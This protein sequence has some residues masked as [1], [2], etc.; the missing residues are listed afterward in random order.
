VTWQAWYPVFEAR[1]D[2]GNNPSISRPNNTIG[3]PAVIKPGL[4]FRGSMHVPLRFR[5]GKFTLFIRPSLTVG[6][7]NNYL[8]SQE[9][10]SYDYGQTM[11]AGRFYFS[12]SHLMAARDIYPRLAQVVDL[13]YASYPFDS[14]NYGSSFTLRTMFHFP[15]FFRNNIIRIRYE[16]EFQSV[17]KFLNFNLVK[18]P[19]G[20]KNIISEDLSFFSADYF[21]PLFYPDLNIGSL[22]YL[23]RI[24]AGIFYDYGKGT[25]NYYLSIGENGLE[26]SPVNN[27]SEIFTSYGAE[28]ISDFHVLRLPYMVSAGV[29]AAWR[30]G[31]YKP[32]L[33]AILSI[34]I[35]GMSIGQ[36]PKL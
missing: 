13:Y 14:E 26:V 9:S 4:S 30:K 35:Y 2:W 21:A 28:L 23:K 16:N 12:N 25:N 29:Q 19:R 27:S 6:Y 34:N 24:R 1:L 11:I 18:Y 22:L 20:Y 17:V 10:A 5:T 8:W 7:E 32:S 15:G 31:D 33:E 36:K 3:D